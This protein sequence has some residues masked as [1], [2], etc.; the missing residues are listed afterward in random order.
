MGG[1]GRVEDDDFDLSVWMLDHAGGRMALRYGSRL[2]V[3]PL[4]DGFRMKCG[5]YSP[6]QAS[7]LRPD[8]RA[9]TLGLGEPTSVPVSGGSGFDYDDWAIGIGTGLGLA[10]LLGAGL[11]ASRQ[12]R[13]RVQPV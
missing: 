3:R 5:E 13:H 8:D 1:E 9:G 7:A 4:G 11:V 12:Q 2:R 6:D 10:L